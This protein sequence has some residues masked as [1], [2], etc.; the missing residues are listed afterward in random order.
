[1]QVKMK[2]LNKRI[3]VSITGRTQKEWESKLK[4]IENHKIRTI[5]LFLEIYPLSQRRKI[6]KALLNSHVKKI[7]LVH[8]RNGMKKQ[9]LKFLEK[10][11]KTKYF[12]IHESGFRYLKDWKGFYKKLWLEMNKD[13]QIPKNV[14]VSKIGGF[15]IDLSHF[16]MEQEIWSKE[17]EYIIRREKIHR[18]FRCNHLNG[19]DWKTNSDLHTITNLKQF[20][21]LKTL[22]KFLFGKY[23]AIETFNSIKDQLK[24]KQHVIKLLS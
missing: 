3:L 10:N 22:P 19:Y 5:A 13:N 14:D 2:N 4:E 20:S 16:K 8:I 6:Y 12:T 9:E 23:I 18:Y 21:Y 1:M 11:F 7:P 17:F 15:C 24:F